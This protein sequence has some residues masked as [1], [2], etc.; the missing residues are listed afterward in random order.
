MYYNC[1]G[2]CDS[3]KFVPIRASDLPLQGGTKF[4]TCTE[5]TG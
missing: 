1:G 3:L 4:H 5:S 2:Y